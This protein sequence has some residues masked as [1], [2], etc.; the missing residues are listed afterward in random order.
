[1]ENYKGNE[2]EPT[3]STSNNIDG[4]HKHDLNEWLVTKEC[5]LY[6]SIYMKLFQEEAKLIHGDGGWASGYLW[7]R[8]VTGRK[9]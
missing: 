7:R 3:I 2:K 9:H 5:Q 6:D 1:M 4:P 8:A